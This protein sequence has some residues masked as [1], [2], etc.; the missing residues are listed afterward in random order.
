MQIKDYKFDRV[1]FA[2][3]LG[4][5]GTLIPLCV[6]LILIADMS[7][8]SVFLMVGLFYILSGLYF[9][10]PMPVQPLKV[11]AAI[12][13]AYPM[14]V[15]LPVLSAAGITF[16]LIMLCLTLTGLIDRLAILFTKQIVRGIQLGLG[17]ILINKGLNFIIS[18]ELFVQAGEKSVIFKDVP[19]NLIIGII[20]VIVTL[21]FSIQ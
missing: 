5:L 15:T 6:P 7:V 2:G 21:F 1:E 11:V 3:S 16:G 8:T 4:D 20:A 19:I 12:A 17:F 13:I 9:K 18:P 14:K 10:L